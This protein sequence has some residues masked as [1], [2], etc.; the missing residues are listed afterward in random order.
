MVEAACLAAAM[1]M[2]NSFVTRLSGAVVRTT[3]LTGVVT[4]L[5]IESAR[6]FR[7]WRSQV[8][9]QLRVRLV[10][11]QVEAVKPSRARTALLAMI[12]VAFLA[13]SAIGAALALQAVRYALIVPVALL[14][15]GAIIAFTSGSREELRG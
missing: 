5:G 2:Q 8:S 12:V 1:G 10:V 4:D 3:H 7:Y 15:G 13:G 9:A 11:G 14:L 6:W